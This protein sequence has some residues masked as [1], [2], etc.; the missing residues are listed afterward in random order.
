MDYTYFSFQTVDQK[1]A[2]LHKTHSITM[3]IRMDLA[4]IFSSLENFYFERTELR[5]IRVS[6]PAYTTTPIIQFVFRKLD[7]LRSKFSCE[8]EIFPN[9]GALITPSYL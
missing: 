4:S 3:M 5:I 2:I 6:Y 8:S 9:W 1:A 7:P